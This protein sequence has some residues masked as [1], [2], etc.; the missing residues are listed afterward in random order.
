[1]KAPFFLLTLVLALPAVAQNAEQTAAARILR[2]VISFHRQNIGY[3]GA[4]LWTYA[5]DLTAQEGEGKANKTSG[6][7]QPPGT[8]TVGEAYLRAWRLSGEKACL[9][10]A[11]E[12]AR[13]LVNA[14][15]KS[16]GWASHF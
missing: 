6:W 9:D 4:Y 1:M 12:C 14:Q 5:A 10:A 11:L 7:T 13:A 3:Q 8:P 15:L 16:G 2:K